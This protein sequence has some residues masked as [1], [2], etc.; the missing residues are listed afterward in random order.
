[1]AWPWHKSLGK[2]ERQEEITTLAVVCRTAGSEE[3]SEQTSPN[4]AFN[5]PGKTQIK[6]P[7]LPFRIFTSKIWT[8][9][10]EKLLLAQSLN[11]SIWKM[12][13]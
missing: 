2:T 4:Q 1:M 11:F 13:R 7:R 6:R 8:D 3:N 10:E 5:M 12:G 9:L